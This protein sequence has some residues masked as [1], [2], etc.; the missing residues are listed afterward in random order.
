MKK[1]NKGSPLEKFSI[2]VEKNKPARWEDLYKEPDLGYDMRLH[3]LYYEQECLCGYSEIPLNPENNSSHIDHFVKREFDS[4]K[5]FDW[6]NFIVSTIDDEFGGKYKDNVY[7][8]KID[9]YR[10][11]FNPVIENMSDYIDYSGDGG[12]VPAENIDD[13]YKEKVKK[14]IEIFN[15]NFRTLK[16]RRKILL[17]H[18]ESC[19]EYNE[20]ELIATFKDYGFI[21]LTNWFIKKNYGQNSNDIS[22]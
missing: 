12:I 4:T 22:D 6:N 15:L 7:K 17:M 1:I 21:S 19:K 20:E 16:N 3:M 13:F 11:I 9:E 2:Y 8:I 14:T 18:L 10:Q 5:T